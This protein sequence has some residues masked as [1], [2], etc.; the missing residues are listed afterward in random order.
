MRNCKYRC[1]DKLLTHERLPSDFV[2]PLFA[3]EPAKP[4]L[5]RSKLGWHL[6]EITA[7]KPAA[8]AE[9]EPLKPEIRK[10]STEHPVPGFAC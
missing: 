1:S 8:P 10:R 9:F 2:L 5:I 3:L 7:R 4:S 6:V